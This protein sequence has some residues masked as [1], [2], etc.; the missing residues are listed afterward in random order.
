MTGVVDAV[1]TSSETLHTSPAQAAL[2]HDAVQI[3][4]RVLVFN[5]PVAPGLD[6]SIDLLVRSDTVEGETRV[7]HNASVMSSTPPH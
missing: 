4:V 2:E 7:P 1:A 6:R 3:D 5:R